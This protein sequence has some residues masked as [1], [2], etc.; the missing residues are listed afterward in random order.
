M[1]DINPPQQAIALG[2]VPYSEFLQL[3]LGLQGGVLVVRVTGGSDLRFLCHS[4]LLKN[5]AEDIQ[6]ILDPFDPADL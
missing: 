4:N 6:K 3:P 2:V 1:N 5:L